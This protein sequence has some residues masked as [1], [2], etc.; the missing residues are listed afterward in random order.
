MAS[1]L[2]RR[3]ASWISQWRQRQRLDID[4][5]RH[6]FQEDVHDHVIPYSPRRG[7]E[8]SG[9]IEATEA[10]QAQIIGV[11][12][13]VSR[14]R[15]S[16]RSDPT[17]IP[18]AIRA[19]VQ[20]MVWRG[21]AVLVIGEPTR[22]PPSVRRGQRP[23]ADLPEYTPLLPIPYGLVFRTPI[24]IVRIAGRDW[25]GESRTIDLYPRSRLLVIDPP[26]SLGGRLGLRLLLRKLSLFPD[27][28][29]NWSTDSMFTEQR[30][31]RFDVSKYAELRAAYHARTVGKW[32]WN[33]RDHSTTH[34]TEFFS[35]YRT[36]SF[37]HAL[38]VLREHILAKLNGFFKQRSGVEGICSLRGVPSAPDIRAVQDEMLRGDISLLQALEKAGVIEPQGG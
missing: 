23:P 24:G 5:I 14:D 25:L 38:A 10:V 17:G 6:M 18:D 33:G 37:H 7:R 2:A 19:I 30:E 4:P 26:W 12:R 31:V 11:L 27:V 34:Q 15:E 22:D 35:V 1:D 16:H 20:Q 8:V 29:P 13:G 3:V 9:V 36:L 21:Y 28:F 32:G